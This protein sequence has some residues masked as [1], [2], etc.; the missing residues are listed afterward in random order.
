[1]EHEMNNEIQSG[2]TQ[3]NERGQ[4]CLHNPA[5]RSSSYY[6]YNMKKSFQYM[7]YRG[8]IFNL[9]TKQ[10]QKMQLWKKKVN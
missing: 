8:H 1:M 9:T 10:R 2:D 3:V 7:Q 5:D 4:A 6:I